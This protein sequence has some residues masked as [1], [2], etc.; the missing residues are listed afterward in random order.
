MTPFPNI[1]VPGWGVTYSIATCR[2]KCTIKPPTTYGFEN[3][4]S[5]TLITSS[6]DLINFQEAL[7]NKEKGRW[8][9][10]M[11]EE[12]QSLYKNQT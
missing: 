2:D 8:M 4:V 3:L 5:Y 11:E 6:G 10:A 12:M 9:G 1:K 7:H